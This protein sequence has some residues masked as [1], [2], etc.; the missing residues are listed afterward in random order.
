ME[1]T[2]STG[3][4]QGCALHFLIVLPSSCL[5]G[6]A[7]L[8][9]ALDGGKVTW[10]LSPVGRVSVSETES[11]EPNPHYWR[12][13]YVFGT[14][15]YPNPVSRLTNFLRVVVNISKRNRPNTSDSVTWFYKLT[16]NFHYKE[17]LGTLSLFF[18]LVLNPFKPHQRNEILW[19]LGAI[20]SRGNGD[21]FSI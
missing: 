18:S 2:Y 14:L 12:E 21:Y 11:M 15:L 10:P 7:Y 20:S 9:W 5:F 4:P 17:H 13:P 8:L 19:E 1:S 6:L 16:T 3:G